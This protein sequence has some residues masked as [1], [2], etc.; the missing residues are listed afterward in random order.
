MTTTTAPAATTYDALVI[1]AGHNGLVAAAYLARAGVRVLVL[2]ARDRVGGATVTEELSPGVRVPTLA[3]TV[4]RLRPAIARELELGRHGLALVAPEV[5]VFAPQPD[6]RAVTLWAD[7]GKTVD[8]LRAWSDD[9]AT[10]FVEFDRSVRVLS[11]FLA[12]LGDEAP[13][14]I[15]A[16]GFGDALLGLRLGRAFRGLGKADGRTILRVLAMAAADFVAE[17]FQQEA[18]RATL[19]WRGVRYTAMGPWSAGT[20]QVLLADAAG[21]D[22]GA[23]GETVFAKGG[24][25]ALAEALAAAA[26]EAGAEIRTG[27]RVAQVTTADGAVTGVV[28]EGGEEIAATRVVSGLDPKQLLTRL[29]DPVTVGPS[30]RW[31]AGNIRTP[32]SVAKVNLVLDGLPEFPAAAGNPRVLRGR[33]QVNT[34]SIDAMEHAFDASKYGR[35]ADEPVLEAT[36]PSLVDPSLVAGAPEG[37]QVMSVLMQWMPTVPEGGDWASQRESI[38]DLAVRTLETVAP[39]LGSRVTARQVLTPADLEA[40]Y[41]LTG[42]H[43]LHAEP[44][45][46]SFFLWRPLLGW[47]RYRMPV[48]GLYLA[49]SGAHPGGGV[50]GAPGRNAAAEV[51]ADRRKRR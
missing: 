9:D 29:V 33:I 18:I 43:P 8:S 26:M 20:T 46:D 23:T 3:H 17:S 41:G 40:E 47:A 7:L 28:L 21:N 13:P 12:D 44:A 34:T 37:T 45:L 48:A 6:G 14:E 2:E 5:R 4:G 25:S 10:S 50:T 32:G 22:G 51:I 24:P 30:M 15:K 38:G 49:G 39:G 19:A 16:P 27:A 1:G 36:I 35:I 42:G 11:R 31:R